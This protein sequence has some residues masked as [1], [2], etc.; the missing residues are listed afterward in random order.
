MT[1][2][3]KRRPVSR[4]SFHKAAATSFGAAAG[5]YFFPALA[6]K[7]LEK[8]TL[9]AIGAGGKGQADIAGAERAGFEIVS[10]V[11]VV[12]IVVGTHRLA[13]KD[14]NFFNLGL[15]V[16]DEEQRF[17]VDVKERLK[18]FNEERPNY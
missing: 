7:K 13:S 8:P 16:I 6:Q 14:V 5:F 18:T 15:L 1:A 3:K 4:R 9:A 10:L 2:P 17:G 12:D 11:D